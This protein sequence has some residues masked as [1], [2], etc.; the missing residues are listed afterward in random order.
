MGFHEDGTK[1]K[2]SEHKLHRDEKS[3][4]SVD[5]YVKRITI[6]KNCKDFKLEILSRN[7]N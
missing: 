1:Q 7:T 6:K 4:R 2:K 3:L 5:T